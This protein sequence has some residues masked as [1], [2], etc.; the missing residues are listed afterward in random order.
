MGIN[1]LRA[2]RPTETNFPCII[3]IWGTRA[4]TKQ[5]ILAENTSNADGYSWTLRILFHWL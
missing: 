1:G 5:S 2:R 3:H 4:G